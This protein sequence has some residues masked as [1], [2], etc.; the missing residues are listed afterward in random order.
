MPAS[1]PF[2]R[3]SSTAQ[4]PPAAKSEPAI[5]AVT[6]LRSPFRSVKRGKVSNP[7]RKLDISHR[8]LALG[9]SVPCRSARMPT[10]RC[11]ELLCCCLFSQAVDRC[12]WEE[13]WELRVESRRWLVAVEGSL[14]ACSTLD[15]WPHQPLLLLKARRLDDCIEDAMELMERCKQAIKQGWSAAPPQWW[16]VQGSINAAQHLRWK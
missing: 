11:V 14:E 13:R 7:S 12:W 8:L 9:S 1:A 6:T 15:W 3:R 16:W 2:G 4:K 10:R 5:E